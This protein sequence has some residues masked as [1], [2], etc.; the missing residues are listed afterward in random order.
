M[1][2][3]I[4]MLA[5]LLMTGMSLSAQDEARLMRFPA[6]HGDQVVFSYAGD[7]YTVEKSGGVARQLTTDEGYEMFARFSP[8]GKTIAFTGQYDGNTE[9]YTIPAEGGIPVRLT[10][11]ATLSRDDLSD[12]MGPNNIVMSWR[13]NNTIVYR[14]RKKTFNSFKGH[15]FQVNTDGSLP[16]QLPLPTGGFNSFSPGRQ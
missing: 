10:Y 15:L 1:K 9:V 5:A 8:D 7:L 14:S 3:F 2:H 13:D 12:R 16:Q 11:T 6:I 4:L